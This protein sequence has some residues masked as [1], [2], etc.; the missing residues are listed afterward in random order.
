MSGGQIGLMG[1]AG[2]GAGA[3][4][5]MA[6]GVDGRLGVRGAGRSDGVAMTFTVTTPD[7][8]SFS[9]SELQL[10]RM[11]ARVAGRGQHGL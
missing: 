4:L 11:V 8:E 6:C 9:R 10:S 5:P 2:A 3:I 1:E 7:A